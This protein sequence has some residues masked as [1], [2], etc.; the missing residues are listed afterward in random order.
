MSEIDTNLVPRMSINNC[1]SYSS[2]RSKLGVCSCEPHCSWDLCRLE[3]GPLDCLNGTKSKWRWNN[4]KNA[5]V[6]QMNKGIKQMD[7]YVRCGND[8]ISS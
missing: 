6:A 1:P 7:K 4:E 8:I 2:Y 3:E 5:W